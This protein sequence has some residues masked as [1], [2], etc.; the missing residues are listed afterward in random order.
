MSIGY[1]RLRSWSDFRSMNINRAIDLVKEL[2]SNVV[3]GPLDGEKMPE[4]TRPGLKYEWD[5]SRW[6]HIQ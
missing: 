2:D 1:G 4:G 6:R 3:G 5:G